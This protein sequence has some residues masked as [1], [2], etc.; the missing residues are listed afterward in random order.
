MHWT[1]GAKVNGIYSAELDVPKI[2]RAT[3][4]SARV[5]TALCDIIDSQD[6]NNYPRPYQAALW[7]AEDLGRP[8][9]YIWDVED[10]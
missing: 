2:T 10:A 9:P 4:T 6:S 5:I 3:C 7:E 1:D 8:E